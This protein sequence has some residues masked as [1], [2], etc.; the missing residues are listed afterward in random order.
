MK[1]LKETAIAAEQG[2]I[3]PFHQWRYNGRSAGNGWN[4]PVNNAGWGT[5]YLN[6][7]G[8]AKSNMWDNKPM[9]LNTYIATST[10]RDNNSTDGI[11]TRLRSRKARRRRSEGSGR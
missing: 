10:A 11:S 1:T 4:S 6:R 8:T 2:M 9:R 5:D 3:T 7:A